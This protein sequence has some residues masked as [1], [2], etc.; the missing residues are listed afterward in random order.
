MQSVN[1]KTNKHIPVEVMWPWPD[2]E[3]PSREERKRYEDKKKRG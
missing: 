1:Q 2:D 3:V